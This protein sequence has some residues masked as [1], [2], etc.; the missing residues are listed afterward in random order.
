MIFIINMG[1]NF[2]K[3]Y[4]PVSLDDFNIN[5]FTKELINKYISNSKLLFVI[6]G[7]SVSG[8]SRLINVILKL[9]YDDFINNNVLFFNL[10]KEQGINYY[11]NDLKNFCQINNIISHNG[12]KKTIIFDDID[13]L[14]EQSQQ[15]FSNLLSSYKNINFIFSCTDINKLQQTLVQRLEYIKIEIID[16][17]FLEKIL[18]KVLICEKIKLNSEMKKKIIKISNF[19]IPNLINILDKMLLLNDI[20]KIHNKDINI[21][22]LYLSSNIL[23]SEFDNYINLCKN[24]NFEESINLIENLY[25]NGYSVIDIIDE[26][27]NY[28]KFF[29]D[30]S[31]EIK[32]KIIKI[33]S[34]YIHIFNNLHE[35]N[36]EL[37]FITNNIIKLF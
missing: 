26:F 28:I 23:K 16:N 4:K 27:F 1:E 21:D 24:K 31:D 14:N 17:L 6:H 9:Y 20:D 30:L 25:A 32:Y 22:D 12:K 19:S 3:K 7:N 34:Y 5:D 37:I 15:I 29:S 2:L 36:I 13:L 10:L 18:N 8:K 11:R 33:L 35:N